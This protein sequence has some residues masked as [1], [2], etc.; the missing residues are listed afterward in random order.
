MTTSMSDIDLGRDE[1]CSSYTAEP[2][3]YRASKAA[4]D[5]MAVNEKATL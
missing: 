3:A 4:V 2:D 5:M 1:M